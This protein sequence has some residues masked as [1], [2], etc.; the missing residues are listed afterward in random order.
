MVFAAPANALATS[1]FLRAGVPGFSASALYSASSSAVPR[2]SAAASSHWT[3]SASRPFFAA[4]KFSATT[5][6]PDGTWTTLTTPG[7]AL[8]E[9]VSTDLT[10]APNTGGRAM[11]AVS[12]P[13]SFTSNA[14]CAVP[15]VFDLASTRGTEAP[16]SVKRLGSFSETSDGTGSPAALPANSPNVALRP[17]G[18]CFMMPFSTVMVDR[19]TPHSLA[20]ASISN[21]LA[22]APALRSWS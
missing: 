3:V 20:A 8:A 7:T 13:G 5:A 10:V 6:T 17:D 19:S 2:V 14:N 15:L 22:V 9:A 16:I 1:P 4:Q 18:A 12:I 11:T 21:A